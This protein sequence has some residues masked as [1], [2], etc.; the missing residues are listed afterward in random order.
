[1]A[2]NTD[3]T[4]KAALLADQR[5]SA[6]GTVRNNVRYVVFQPAKWTS[7]TLYHYLKD[8]DDYKREAYTQWSKTSS[9]SVKYYNDAG[10]QVGSTINLTSDTANQYF[11]VG[12]RPESYVID[13][14]TLQYRPVT[15]LELL[16]EKS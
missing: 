5:N 1:M 10:T 2:I 12:Y 15:V 16:D 9:A 6:P 13:K 4:V 11:S 14:A 7:Q 3:D 8:G